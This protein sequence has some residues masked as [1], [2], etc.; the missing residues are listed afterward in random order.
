MKITALTLLQATEAPLLLRAE[1][2]AESAAY[3]ALPEEV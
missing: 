2:E 1:T 3:A